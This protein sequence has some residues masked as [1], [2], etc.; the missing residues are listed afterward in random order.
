MTDSVVYIVHFEMFTYR[1]FYD[2]WTGSICNICKTI[3]KQH[4]QYS[5]VTLLLFSMYPHG[6][7]PMVMVTKCD[8]HSYLLLT[9]PILYPAFYVLIQVTK[10]GVV[11]NILD[12]VKVKTQVY[13]IRIFLCGFAYG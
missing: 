4:T 9:M 1:K 7:L 10:C 3:Y 5:Y 2:L 13:I 8:K 11:E 6:G 12:W